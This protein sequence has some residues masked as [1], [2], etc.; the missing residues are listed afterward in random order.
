[1]PS[2]CFPGVTC[3]NLDYGNFQCGDC[4]AGYEWNGTDCVDINEVGKYANVFHR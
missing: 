1:V 3:R 4:P 2:P